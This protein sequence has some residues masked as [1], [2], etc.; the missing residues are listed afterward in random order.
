MPGL[1]TSSRYGPEITGDASSA[2][3][4]DFVAAVTVSRSTPPSR[5]TSTRTV[6]AR[7]EP[8]TSTS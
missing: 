4:I 5:S 7:P 2:W 6:R 3:E 8:E 1:L